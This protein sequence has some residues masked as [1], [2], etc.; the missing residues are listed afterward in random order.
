MIQVF[1]CITKKCVYIF[2][3][4]EFYSD[5]CVKKYVKNKI[6]VPMYGQFSQI[7]IKKCKERTLCELRMQLFSLLL[8]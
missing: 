5:I 3:K 2:L 8:R 1:V 6:F 7:L 4:Q